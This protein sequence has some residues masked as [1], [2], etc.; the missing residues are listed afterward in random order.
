MKT[1]CKVEWCDNEVYANSVCRPH[2]NHIYR[3]GELRRFTHTPNEII[4]SGE[5]A[6][7]VLYKR[8]MSESGIRVKISIS[9]I[10]DIKGLR[11]YYTN[12]YAKLS[13]SKTKYLHQI[14]SKCEYPLV[15]DHINRD[16]LDCRIQNLR[17]VTRSENNKNK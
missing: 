15:C 7:I 17:C 16:K 2:T 12:G 8:D 13:S 1:K 9:S 14:L 11:F 3:Y 10:E 6:E 4:I 5:Y